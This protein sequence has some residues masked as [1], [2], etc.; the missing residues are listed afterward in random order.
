MKCC[1]EMCLFV[2]VI[3]QTM[4]V[5]MECHILSDWQCV[6]N[7]HGLASSQLRKAILTEGL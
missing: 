2:N 7:S 3:S 1:S 6:H 5:V 4:P